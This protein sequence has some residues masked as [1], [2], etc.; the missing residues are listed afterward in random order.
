MA[1]RRSIRSTVALAGADDRAKRVSSQFLNPFAAIPVFAP[2]PRT[3]ARKKDEFLL[4]FNFFF[5]T[6]H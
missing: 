1:G 5:Y 4:Y 3:N 2:F 6:F